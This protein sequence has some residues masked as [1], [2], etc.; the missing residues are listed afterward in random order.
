MEQCI[1][2]SEGFARALELADLM[3]TTREPWLV[4]MCMHVYMLRDIVRCLMR[5]AGV[6]GNLPVMQ[7]AS[8]E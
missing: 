5:Y 4:H 8:T 2:L 3:N 7:G 1:R 6:A